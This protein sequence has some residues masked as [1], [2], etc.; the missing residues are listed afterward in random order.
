L[1]AVRYTCLTI[2]FAAV[3][4]ACGNDASARAE[5]CAKHEGD[6]HCGGQGYCEAV[7]VDGLVK[8][9]LSCRRDECPDGYLC[10]SFPGVDV[11]QV[12]VKVCYEP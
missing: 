6:D 3:L 11:N 2:L 1:G 8:C 9:G 12:L 10:G 7:R 5:E 4:A